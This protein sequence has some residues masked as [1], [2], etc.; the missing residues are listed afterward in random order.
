VKRAIALV[1]A[2]VGLSELPLAQSAQSQ[3]FTVIDR[4][5]VCTTGFAGGVPD[6]IRTINA[7]VSAKRGSEPA[8]FDPSIFLNTGASAALVKVYRQEGSGVAPYVLVHRRRC[9]QLKTRLPLAGEERSAPAI[10]F[11]TGCQ[12]LEAPPRIFVRLRAVLETPAFWS[13]YRRDYL[14]ARAKALEAFMIVRAH[15]DRTPIAFASFP[16]RLRAVLSLPAL[17]RR[18]KR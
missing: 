13:V 4:T 16:R 8:Q 12:V 2:V 5:M 18:V 3:R 6:K 9:T 10:T 7:S 17:Y 15:P 1:I 11:G 14:R